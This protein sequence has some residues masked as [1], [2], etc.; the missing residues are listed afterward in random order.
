MSSENQSELVKRIEEIRARANVGLEH[1]SKEG[2]PC[3]YEM[4]HLTNE[5]NLCNALL[6]AVD[7]A[8]AFTFISKLEM[9]SE[10]IEVFRLSSEAKI[11]AKLNGELG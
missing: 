11:L 9:S 1:W 6:L 8:A 4:E 5:V 3:S 10:N 7:E 2:E